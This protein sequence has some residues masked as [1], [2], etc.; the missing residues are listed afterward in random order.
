MSSIRFR[1]AHTF[2]F[3]K[4]CT[5]TGWNRNASPVLWGR[6]LKSCFYHRASWISKG[7]NKQRSW[8]TLTESNAFKSEAIYF[9]DKNS[10]STIENKCVGRYFFYNS[11]H[12]DS[13]W[14]SNISIAVESWPPSP[15]NEH[16]A[17]HIKTIFTA[18]LILMLNIAN[19][20]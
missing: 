3:T 1:R 15:Y 2:G 13:N 14:N 18:C 5:W 4:G 8:N 17:M 10:S 19:K 20:E 9:T 12:L 7:Y 16:T 11:L 6:F